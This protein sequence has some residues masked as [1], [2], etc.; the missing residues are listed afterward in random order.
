[1]GRMA[2]IL[3]LAFVPCKALEVLSRSNELT[4]AIVQALLADS[5][6]SLG[7]L[8]PFDGTNLAANIIEASSH[9]LGSWDATAVGE[10]VALLLAL[11]PI[12]P[13]AVFGH[14]TKGRRAVDGD[15][16]SEGEEVGTMDAPPDAAVQ[17]NWKGLPRLLSPEHVSACL[18]CI[19]DETSQYDGVSIQLIDLLIPRTNGTIQRVGL[20]NTIAFQPGYIQKLYHFALD[21]R[22]VMSEMFEGTPSN[23][24][25]APIIACLRVFSDAFSHMLLTV[26]DKEFYQTEANDHAGSASVQRKGLTLEQVV[27]MSSLLKDVAVN[28]YMHDARCPFC[29]QIRPFYPH[30]LLLW[31]S[32][33][34]QTC[35][36]IRIS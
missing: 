8:S 19:E 18:R 31:G 21:N 5:Q 20:L 3:E 10:Y 36:S 7:F 13:M 6:R 33:R 1:M 22:A 30:F 2:L 34:S 23:T 17:D 16:D 12:I 29:P 4:R 25:Y 27:S 11:I 32:F 9:H 24:S 15:L 28:L 14:T 35:S 26:D